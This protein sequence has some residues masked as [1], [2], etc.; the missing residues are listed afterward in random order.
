MESL[1]QAI[2]RHVRDMLGLRDDE[3]DL[4]EPLS[5]YGILPVLLAR[6]RDR[7]EQREPIRLDPERVFACVTAR[8]IARIASPTP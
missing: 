8:D 7:I 1:E 4:E 3:L 5:R 6:L 2:F